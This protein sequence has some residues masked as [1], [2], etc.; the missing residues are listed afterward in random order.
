MKT[1]KLAKAEPISLLA[2]EKIKNEESSRWILLKAEE[3]NEKFKLAHATIGMFAGMSLKERIFNYKRLLKQYFLQL[4]EIEQEFEQSEKT[5]RSQ[6][7]KKDN[8][9]Q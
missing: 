6:L 7:H 5:L 2:E 1:E 3:Y 9:N 8:D 4:S